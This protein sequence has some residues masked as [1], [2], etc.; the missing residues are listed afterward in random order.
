MNA[1]NFDDRYTNCQKCGHQLDFD[2]ECRNKTCEYYLPKQSNMTTTKIRPFEDRVLIKP[3]QAPKMTDTGLYI[4]DNVQEKLQPARGIVMAVGP[5]KLMDNN[6]ILVK[7]YNLIARF[8]N[9]FHLFF[10][11][12]TSWKELP[13]KEDQLSY[14]SIPLKPGDRVAYGKHAGTP[15]EDPETKEIFIMMRFA[16]VFAGLDEGE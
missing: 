14:L 16:D 15:I 3:D 7:I 1:E 6:A 13:N 2:L 11:L 10:G 12:K 9:F 4:P 5:G 8:F